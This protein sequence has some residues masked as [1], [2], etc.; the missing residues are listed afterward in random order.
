[1]KISKVVLDI[2]NNRP[3]SLKESINERISGV[4]AEGI[5]EKYEEVANNLQEREEES[6]RVKYLNFLESVIGVVSEDFSLKPE[7]RLEQ[8][9]RS[10]LNML[11]NSKKN[12]NKHIKPLS[13]ELKNH[14]KNTPPDDYR[15]DPK[16]MSKILTRKGGKS[17]DRK[18]ENK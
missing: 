3:Y 6:S 2:I 14:L 4:I 17:L 10:N 13:K 16:N 15:Y 1:M 12:G 9:K 8:K 7:N 5:F 18:W 11:S